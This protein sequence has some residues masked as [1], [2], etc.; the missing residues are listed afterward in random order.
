[1]TVWRVGAHAG[2]AA[3]WALHATD[4]AYTPKKKSTCFALSTGPNYSFPD[5]RTAA[6]EATTAACNNLPPPSAN[7]HSQVGCLGGDDYDVLAES[8]GGR[9]YFAGEATTRKWPATMHGAYLSGLREVRF[10]LLCITSF[11]FLC[12]HHVL[13]VKGLRAHP[14]QR[15]KLAQC[16]GAT[17]GLHRTSHCVDACTQPGQ[18]RRPVP[19]SPLLLTTPERDE[20]CA[21]PPP[22]IGRQRDGVA[23]DRRGPQDA[24]AAG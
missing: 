16:D 3:L 15:S 23:D 4:V 20:R 13:R 6:W 24:R 22:A 21:R 11:L 17:Q 2:D 14:L 10:C 19:R 1:M 8:L 12:G 7:T 9:V 5:Y 18:P